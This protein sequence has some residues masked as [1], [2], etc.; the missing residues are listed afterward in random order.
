MR[1][2][3]AVT[4]GLVLLGTTLQPAVLAQATEASGRK[5]VSR[6]TPVY[7]ELARKM[8]VEGSVKL[9]VTVA[10]NGIAKNVEA[11]GGSPLLVKAA[12]DAMYKFR[13]AAAAQE[14]K[15]LIEIRFHR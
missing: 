8:N 7:P 12:E 6:V 2:V 15:E 5:I 4:I 1:H 9:L 10:P 3:V 14:S 11:V 13:W